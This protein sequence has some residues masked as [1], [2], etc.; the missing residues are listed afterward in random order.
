MRAADELELQVAIL[1]DALEDFVSGEAHILVAALDAREGHNLQFAD[2]IIFFALPWSPP[3]IQQSIDGIDRLGIVERLL[4]L[5][6]S[7]ERNASLPRA[8]DHL[9]G[10]V[11]RAFYS[12]ARRPAERVPRPAGEPPDNEGR[13]LP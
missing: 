13:R 12:E 10:C 2:E 8:R 9:I 1:K 5:V 3:D 6:A 7:V 11:R 4:V